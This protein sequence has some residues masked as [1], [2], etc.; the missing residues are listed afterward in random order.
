MSDRSQPVAAYENTVT[1]AGQAVRSPEQ[2]LLHLPI[3]GPTSRMLAYA[4]DYVLIF[5]ALVGVLVSLILTTPLLHR[6]ETSLT[7]VFGEMAKGH[8]QSPADNGAFLVM[9]AAFLLVQFILEWTYFVIAEMISGGRSLG[10]AL[11]GLRVVRDGGLPISLRESLVRNLLRVVD[12]LPTNYAVGLVTMMVSAD[13]KRLGDLA[14]GTIVIRLDRS[15]PAP[16]LLEADTDGGGFRFD[17]VQIARLGVNERALLRQTLRRLQTL[18]P[19]Q[20]AAILE[21]AVEVLRARIGYEPVAAAEREQ[22]LR[23]LL[24]AVRGRESPA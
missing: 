19:E 7:R 20:A 10:K 23:A 15:A 22:F 13:G 14:A 9:V 24:H 12:V 4:I 1:E 3:A 8:P 2:V 16:A 6:I 18:P 17:H 21:Q 11:V 5:M